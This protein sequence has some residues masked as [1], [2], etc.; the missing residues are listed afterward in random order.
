MH[1]PAETN[2]AVHCRDKCCQWVDPVTGRKCGSTFQLQ[3][4]HRQPIW[5]GG[6]DDISNL[7]ILCA[8]HNRAKYQAGGWHS[9]RHFLADCECKAKPFGAALIGPNSFGRRREVRGGGGGS[10]A[11]KCHGLPTMG[12]WKNRQFCSPRTKLERN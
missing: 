3:I 8:A 10:P 6:T 12:S 1:I 11:K 7:Q 9:I 5:A 2:R 4:D